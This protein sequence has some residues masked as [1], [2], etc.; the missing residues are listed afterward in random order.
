MKVLNKDGKAV[1]N[2]KLEANYVNKELVLNAK[3]Q[4]AGNYTVVLTAKSGEKK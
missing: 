1:E 4:D 2:Q 3:G